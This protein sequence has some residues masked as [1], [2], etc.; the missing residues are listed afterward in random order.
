[1]TTH[2]AYISDLKVLGGNLGIEVLQPWVDVSAGAPGSPSATGRGFADLIAG[3]G[4]QWAPIKIGPG[5]FAHRF[6]FD[7]GLPTGQYDARQQ[8][9]AGNNFVILNPYYAMT[10]EVGKWEASARLHY[11]WNSVNN[12][13]FVGLGAT[14]VQAGQAFHM[15][16]AISY[17]VASGVR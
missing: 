16:Y 15:N 4:V 17:E 2:I 13:P 9:N 7:V 14:T 10:Y 11:L 6:I 5:V 12:D 3:I 1:T 8:V